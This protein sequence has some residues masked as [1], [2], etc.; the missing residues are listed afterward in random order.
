MNGPRRLLLLLAFNLLVG[1]G[2]W[3]GFRW[4]DQRGQD[5][6]PPPISARTNDKVVVA[7][8]ITKLAAWPT[9]PAAHPGESQVAL[10][11]WRGQRFAINFWASW[12]TAC[13][14]EK[15][16]LALLGGAFPR[17]MVGLGTLDSVEQIAAS[18]AQHPHPYPVAVDADGTLAAE[19]GVDVLPQTLVFDEQG[20]L[21]R[22]FRGV[23][24]GVH[25]DAIRLLLNPSEPP[26]NN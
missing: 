10:A 16:L 18:E 11:R 6:V 26:T 9:F 7:E 23:L 4:S 1:L 12:C 13:S 24:T 8:P 2:M 15:P 22:R 5:G 25:A 19:L 20:Q 21:L 3:L 17:Q 14:E